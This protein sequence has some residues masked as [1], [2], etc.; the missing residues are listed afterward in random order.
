MYKFKLKH[1][2]NYYLA[3]IVLIGVIVSMF[4]FCGK[5]TVNLYYNNIEKVV[6]I[7]S[8][9]DEDEVGYATGCFISKYGEILTNKH[10][11]LN[12][13][14]EQQYLH[15]QVRLSNANNWQEATIVKI[16][17]TDDLALIKID[18]VNSKFFSINYNVKTGQEI[19]TIGN[20]NGFGLCFTNGIVSSASKNII[21][22]ETTINTIQTNFVINEG[23]SGGPVFLDDGSLIGII[24]F[25]L[26]DKGGNV[27]QGMAFAIPAS[28]INKFISA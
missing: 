10:V 23:N 11:V 24:S 18:I 4:A 21:Y 8:F 3:I 27:I 13:I 14:T 6:E 16:S 17:E 25:R 15:V 28:T 9:D 2:I 1:W 19:Y 20:P 7:R 5:S 22:N 26:K 12:A